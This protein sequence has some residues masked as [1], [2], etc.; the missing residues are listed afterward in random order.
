LERSHHLTDAGSRVPRTIRVRADR[1]ARSGAV[2]GMDADD[3]AQDLRLDLIERAP[4]YE[5]ARASFETFAD[6]VT[7]NRV[8]TLA[9]PTARLRAERGMRDLH[10]ASDAS[11]DGAGLPLA[12]TLPESSGLHAA[13]AAE[14]DVVFGLR[15]DVGRLLAALPP[16][17][18]QVAVALAE[19]SPTEAARALGLSRC[20]IYARLGVIR[21][22]AFALGLE[23]YVRAPRHI[24]MP[25][26]K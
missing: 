6:R 1:L 22:A 16:A 19:M 13:E 20:T 23:D 4:R 9:S 10:G 18:R 26:G 17:C 7:A 5:P 15:R 3:I 21:A 14:P 2:P 12:D 8:A 24:A 11:D 25:A